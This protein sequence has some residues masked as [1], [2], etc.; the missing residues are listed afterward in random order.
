M[1]SGTEEELHVKL[2]NWLETNGYEVGGE[3]YVGNGQIDLVGKKNDRYIG[4]EVKT[5]HSLWANA[6]VSLRKAKTTL[7]QVNKYMKSEFLDEVYLCCQ[8]SD[9]VY[10]K[11]YTAA[12]SVDTVN[13]LGTVE[14]S[15][16]QGSEKEFVEEAEQLHRT[17]TPTLS[18]TNES[19]VQH[20]VW[21]WA[22]KGDRLAVREGL[23]PKHN[24][25]DIALTEASPD[26]TEILRNQTEYSH[27]GIEVKGESKIDI[28]E[29]EEQLENY[30]QSG[31]LT[32][33]YV[34]IP[35][36]SKE[37]IV[38]EYGQQ[39]MGSNNSSVSSKVGFITVDQD[40][41][42]DIV[43]EPERIE[44]KFDGI[45]CG[46]DEYYPVGLG[47]RDQEDRSRDEFESISHWYYHNRM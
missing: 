42:I 7:R 15:L 33:L 27:I 35:E 41:D 47:R 9:E 19:W 10:E 18:R 40:G 44:M 34:A 29:F 17:E 4:F 8:R 37:R 20:Q 1:P 43:R 21:D 30:I 36:T 6:G 14:I 46:S 23:L 22:N 2:W 24:F 12:S 38:P 25:V 13:K 28:D 45:R 5:I 32:H 16:N 39:T 31:G 3:V 26:V 11:M